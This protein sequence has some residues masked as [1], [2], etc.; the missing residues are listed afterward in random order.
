MMGTRTSA[1]RIK[2]LLFASLAALI[3]VCFI[4]SAALPDTGG[5]LF[6]G[7]GLKQLQWV[8][9]S[10][11][12][13]FGLQRL[14]AAWIRKVALPFLFLV[15]VLC[16]VVLAHS[17]AVTVNGASRW[18]SIGSL[19]LQPGELSKPAV[20]L[21]FAWFLALP[22]PPFEQVRP[23]DR[24]MHWIVR[25]WIPLAL[26]VALALLIERQP[27]LGTAVFAIL[28]PFGMLLCGG[29]RRLYGRSA[30]RVLVWLTVSMLGVSALLAMLEPYRLQRL[31]SFTDTS[32]REAIEGSSY[33][34][35]LSQT[36]IAL[37]GLGGLGM[38]R[39]HAK[40]LLPAATTDYIY[41]TMAEEI[42]IFAFLVVFVT[43][44]G[45]FFWLI[46]IGVNQSDEFA[47]YLAFG[48]AFWIAVQALGNL[49]MV[50]GMIP[51]IGIPL[52]FFSYGG[53]SLIS[54]AIGL[55]A[56]CSLIKEPSKK[57]APVAARSNRWGYGRA[58]LSRT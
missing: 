55:G 51:S 13:C 10:A 3:G 9:I 34:P 25:L 40:Y 8:V 39:G 24:R 27:D 28:I 16:V 4:S 35:F 57:E 52:P 46:R 36:A 26:F 14:P 50:T 5:A 18:I 20:V 1:D 44:G 19:Q 54:L 11:A 48:M 58:R 7:K 42:G 37:G 21:A 45:I 12:L 49:F 32:S 56:V 33:Q 23:A 31:S 2:L 22:W 53:S 15:F 29:A 6:S 30:K 17:S 41:T 38:G 47:R 43:L